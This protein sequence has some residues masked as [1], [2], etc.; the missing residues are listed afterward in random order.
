[1]LI[2]DLNLSFHHYFYPGTSEFYVGTGL[3]MPRCSYAT[4]DQWVKMESYPGSM[5]HLNE[6]ILR[7][8]SAAGL[9]LRL[10]GY[11]L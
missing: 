9:C 11:L 6:A 7:T 1:M 10:I 2:P 4:G 5:K 3:G 8:T